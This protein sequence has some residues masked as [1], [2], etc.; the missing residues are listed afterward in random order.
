MVAAILLAI[1]AQNAPARLVGRLDHPAIAEA[2]GIA[3]SRRYPGIFWVHNDSGNPPALFAVTEQGRLVREYAV[4]APNVDWED[5]ALDDQGRLY[6]A[7]IGNNGLRLPIRMI[8][9]LAE[10]DPSQPATTPLRPDLVTCYKFPADG[11]FDAEGLY[12]DGAWAVVLAKY[13][14][15]RPA[16]LFRVPIDPPAPLLR[17]ATA[18]KVGTLADFTQPATSASLS[19]DGGRL[20]V[21]SI[22]EVR[23]YRRAPGG[24]WEFLGRASCPEGQVEAVAWDGLDL[25]LAG[26]DRR[27]H[28]VAE[29]HW[30][31]P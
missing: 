2:S 17:P 22:H 15:G 24:A 30:R 3:R 18:E 31:G 20:A 16:D 21:A 29:R 8:Y 5:L 12:L 6:L 4:A 13:R 1:L 27:V 10:P 7:D 11:R 25:V 19:D 14:D 28:R 23:V 9:R 26:E